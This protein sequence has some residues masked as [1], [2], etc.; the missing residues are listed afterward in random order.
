MSF[1]KRC[2]KKNMTI[3]GFYV[4]SYVDFWLLFVLFTPRFT[5]PFLFMRMSKYVV[6]KPKALPIGATKKGIRGGLGPP[7]KEQNWENKEQNGSKKLQNGTFLGC[8][9]S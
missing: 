8:G 1:T 5:C 9:N 4:S 3:P 6:V 7:N 2:I